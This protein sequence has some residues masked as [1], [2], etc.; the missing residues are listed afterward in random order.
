MSGI[1]TADRLFSLFAP[2]RPKG[3]NPILAAQADRYRDK[4]TAEESSVVERLRDL[5]ASSTRDGVVFQSIIVACLQTVTRARLREEQVARASISLAQHEKLDA[6]LQELIAIEGELD[7]ALTHQGRRMLDLSNSNLAPADDTRWW[8]ALSEAI[9]ELEDGTERMAS[10]VGNQ[11][12]GAE[13]RRLAG[14]VVRLLHKHHVQLV[15]EAE[16]WMA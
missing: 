3:I 4:E 8:Y 6:L 12:R 15:A 14:T 7:D 5:L 11:P 16:E 10:L 1:S 2:I 13:V 9:Q